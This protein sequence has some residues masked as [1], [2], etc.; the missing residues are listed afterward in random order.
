MKTKHIATIVL[1]SL[2]ITTVASGANNNHDPKTELYLRIMSDPVIQTFVEAVRKDPKNHAKIDALLMQLP[3]S[4]LDLFQ[5]RM[6]T[7]FSEYVVPREVVQWHER[8]A[9]LRPQLDTA[10]QMLTAL[11]STSPGANILMAAVGTN[12]NMASTTSPAPLDYQGEIQV[13]VNKNNPNQIVAAANTWDTPTGCDQTQAIF[14]SGND[15]VSWN[16]TC[17]PSVGAYGVSCPNFDDI[18]FGSDPAVVW[19]SNNKVFVN[20][21]LLCCDFFCQ[22]GF[23]PPSSALAVARSDNGGATWAA[24]G[25]VSNRLCDLC[26]LDDKEFYAIDNRASSPFFGRHYECWDIENDEKAAWSNTGTTGSWTIVDLPPGGPGL[27]DIGCDMAIQANGIVHLIFDGLTCGTSTCSEEKTF[28]TKSTNGGQT[29]SSPLLVKQHNIFGF[30]SSANIPP[31]DNRGIF[32][33]GAIDVDNSSGPFN[34]RLYV[35]YSDVNSGASMSTSDIYVARSNDGINWTH[36]KVNDDATNTAQFH[37][38]LVVDQTN[39]SVVVGWH[40]SRNDL[41]NNRKVDYYLSRSTDG[42]LTWEANTKVTQPSSEFSNSTI[43]YSDENTSDNP[44]RNPNQ[45][46]EYLGLDV[47][48]NTA[49]MSW[50][51]TRQ[52]F[53]NNPSNLQ[54]ENIG[55]AAITFS[56]SGADTTPPTTSI[57]SPTAGANINGT[58]PVNADANDNV[59]VTKVEFYLDG[60]TLLGTDLNSPYGVNWDTTTTTNGG[61]NLMS[62]VYDAANNTGT[63]AQVNVTVNNGD[64]TPPSTSITAPT[65]GSNVSGTIQVNADASDNIGVTK[66][67]F[68]LDGTTLIATDTDSPYSVNWNT[69]TATNGGHNLTSKAYDAANNTGTSAQVNVTVNNGDTTPPTTSIIAPAAGSNVSGTVQVKATASDNVGIKKVDFYLDGTILLGSDTSAPYQVK[70]NTRNVA[71]GTHTLTSKATDT[72]DNVATSAGVTV[73]V[74]NRV[75]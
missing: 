7:N 52:F 55:F 58:I 44:G 29:W 24:H 38:F 3:L 47:H 27:F 60:T 5:I 35:V 34:G 42:G 2:F 73:N 19:D 22:I 4:P 31:Q 23:G 72:S 21:M 18:R 57:T 6:K 13:S 63:S 67:E 51:D 71:N 54:K 62:K 12:R 69:T 46:G 56:D 14:S 50:T 32:P 61:H 16:Y 28:Y 53:P 40:D 41:A 10:I 66:V 70:W 68:Y 33:F 15:G 11:M 64:I 48:A 36:V 17:A 1:C 43:S 49:Y 75:R 59:A 25:I 37:P 30:N 26:G 20:Y 45:Y 65:E 74:N 39:G 8:W 9:T